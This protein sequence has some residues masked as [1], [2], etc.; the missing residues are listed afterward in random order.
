M[1]K[2]IIYSVEGA[3]STQNARNPDAALKLSYTC[4]T[5]N[6]SS[7]HVLSAREFQIIVNLA[8]E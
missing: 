1:N 7:T 8:L 2:K 3:L 4:E 6:S 5:V